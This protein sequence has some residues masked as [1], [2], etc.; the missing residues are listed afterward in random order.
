VKAD[1]SL[2]QVG[3]DSLEMLVLP[4]GGVGVVSIADS[5]AAMDLIKRAWDA[6]KLVAA[7]C[8]AP[9]LLAEL[10]VLDGK[11]IVC[12]PSV[13]DKVAA[14]G[15]DIQHGL[16]VVRDDNLITGIAAGASIVF[17][18]ELVAVLRGR[19]ASEEVRRS[20]FYN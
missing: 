12:Y 16:A 9:S 14:A 20:I 8:A 2:E 7:I 1:M 5:P 15:G 19:E 17:G 6:G 4:G 13:Y 10:R 3:F 11:R 18:L